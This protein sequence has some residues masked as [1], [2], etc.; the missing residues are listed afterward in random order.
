[1]RGLSAL[2]VLASSVGAVLCA[3]CNFVFIKSKILFTLQQAAAAATA[4]CS[5]CRPAGGCAGGGA[6]GG[7]D[8]GAGAGLILA[9]S[10]L[11]L[12]VGDCQR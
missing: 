9:L 6:D 8:G 7:A 4:R 1:M 10:V 2:S 11:N 3:T 5:S 12:F